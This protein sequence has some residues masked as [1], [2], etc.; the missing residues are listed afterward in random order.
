MSLSLHAFELGAWL[1]L[2]SISTTFPL[3]RIFLETIC[4]E[5]AMV[6]FAIH[7]KSAAESSKNQQVER[8]KDQNKTKTFNIVRLLFSTGTNEKQ[9]S[10]MILI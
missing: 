6:E 9:D 2:Y 3:F 1:F 8:S 5:P 4:Q 7:G 10:K